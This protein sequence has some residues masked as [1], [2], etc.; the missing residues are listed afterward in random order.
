LT[1]VEGV[2]GTAT[3][4]LAAGA[5]LLAITSS[6]QLDEL[7]R[8]T[9]TAV[10]HAN[11]VLEAI[12]NTPFDQIAQ[13]NWTTWSAVARAESLANETVTVAVDPQMSQFLDVTVAVDWT[14]RGRPRHLAVATAVAPVDQP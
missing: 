2:V 12:R 8:E 13:R 5:L 14:A 9:T 3:A 11:Q 10:T 1:L 4:V 7:A 6:F